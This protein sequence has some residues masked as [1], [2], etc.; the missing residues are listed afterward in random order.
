M[1]AGVL[2]FI[3]GIAQVLRCILCLHTGEWL[4]ARDDVE[5]TE[6]ILLET[7]TLDSLG[8]GAEALDVVYPDDSTPARQKGRRKP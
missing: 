5:E 6:K 8:R 2:L 7:K 1:A 4:R 3:Q